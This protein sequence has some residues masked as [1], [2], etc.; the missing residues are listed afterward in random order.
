MPT[1]HPTIPPPAEPIRKTFD[2]WN[3][4]STGHQR[5]DNRLAGSTSWRDSRAMK[6]GHQFRSGE[7]GGKRISDSVGAGS[8]EF[9]KDGRKE[10]ESWERGAPGLREKGWRDVSVMMM[11]GGGVEKE[12]RNIERR[13]KLQEFPETVQSPSLQQDEKKEE[14]LFSGLTIYLNGSTAPLISDHKLKH[15]LAT[16]GANI[17][18][19]L[20]RRS[21]THV[22]LGKH[23]DGKGGGAGGGL[24]GS[25]IQKEISRVGG[26][27]VKFVGVEWVI[28][29]IN[30]G[31]RLPEARFESLSIAPKGVKSVYGMF[32]RKD[33]A[34]ATKT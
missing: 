7:G 34:N 13:R 26:K 6:L 14:Q 19:A 5:A 33:D 22:I 31:K 32:Q 21:V 4:S 3:S 24:S 20:G 25:K 8:L 28:E 27:G 23:N 11:E 29:S 12:R 10:N 1:P 9:G 18:I 30:A 17:S 15:L 16:H 2:P